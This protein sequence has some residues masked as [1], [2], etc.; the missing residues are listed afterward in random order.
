MVMV[1]STTSRRSVVVLVLTLSSL[2]ILSGVAVSMGVGPPVFMV[3]SMR[4]SCASS[5]PP[6]RRLRMAKTTMPPMS[7]ET[8]NTPSAIMKAF[9]PMLCRMPPEL[10]L[11]ALDDAPDDAAAPL[12]LLALVASD[13]E[14]EAAE[15]VGPAVLPLPAVGMSA[16]TLT[17]SCRTATS[18]PVRTSTARTR[19]V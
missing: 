14:D 5:D 2:R 4:A 9:I 1:V 11:L 15:D 19:T 16:R 12:A 10:A 6:P 8:K 13:D 7:A 18:W 3:A 17:T